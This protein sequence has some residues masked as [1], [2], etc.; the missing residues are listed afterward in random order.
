MVANGRARREKSTQ[1]LSPGGD[2][3][4][5]PHG[6]TAGP[7]SVRRAAGASGPDLRDGGSE[8]D[9]LR[10]P[11]RSSGSQRSRQGIDESRSAWQIYQQ[12][13]PLGISGAVGKLRSDHP[14]EQQG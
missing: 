10:R 7:A 12:L 11:K 6:A 5:A 13:P 8:A 2:A 1:R 4:A 9:D 3:L 14:E